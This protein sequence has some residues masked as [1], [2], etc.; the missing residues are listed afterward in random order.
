MDRI[1]QERYYP[2]LLPSTI[3]EKTRAKPTFGRV[4]AT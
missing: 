1:Q 4:E 3:L 2:A